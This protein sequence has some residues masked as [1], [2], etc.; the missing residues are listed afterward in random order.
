MEE[1]IIEVKNIHH[2]F[3]EQ[4]ILNDISMSFPRGRLITITGPSGCGKSTLLKIIAGLI[5]PDRGSVTIEG[6]DVFS[7]SRSKLFEMR[8]YFCFVF[9]D[10]ALISNL[11]VFNNVALP[12]RYHHSLSEEEVEKRVLNIL[13]RCGIEGIRDAL[14]AHLSLGQRKLV[15]F[16]RGLVVEP[17]LIFLDEPVSGI[18]AIARKKMIDIIVPLRDDPEI[19]LIVVSHNIDFIKE[20]ADYIALLHDKNLI[21]YGK[22]DE[23]LK[24]SNPILQSILSIIVDEGALVAKEVLGI[25]KGEE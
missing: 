23:I 9:Q 19:T 14:P 22:R 3:E 11:N 16:A 17:R 7:A 25:L 13:E 4:V 12:L 2:S 1:N 24:S 15:G 18:D 8:K 20:Y 6:I 5:Y 10:S 21:A